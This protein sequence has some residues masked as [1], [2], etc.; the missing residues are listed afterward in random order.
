MQQQ[1]ERHE[2]HP[3]ERRHDKE[4]CEVKPVFIPMFCD[5]N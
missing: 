1:E 5:F 4:D 3:H 2:H